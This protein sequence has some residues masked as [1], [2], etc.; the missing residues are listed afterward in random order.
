MM[1]AAK[2]GH[3]TVTP[4]YKPALEEKLAFALFHHPELTPFWQ[5]TL[6]IATREHLERLLPR[7]WILTRR[8]VPPTAIIPG[9][10]W[11]A[12]PYPIFAV[13]HNPAKKSA[14]SCSS[15]RDSRNWLGVAEGCRSAMICRR[16]SGLRRWSRRS[17]PF[18][19]PPIFC[20]SFTKGV[21]SSPPIS[22]SEPIGWCR[23]LGRAR[24]SSLLFCRRRQ[25]RTRRNPRHPLSS[26]QKSYSRHGRRHHGA[27]RDGA[28]CS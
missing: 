10:R 6:T 21:S 9:L 1:Y 27:L 7:T 22:T 8:P 17:K 14:N 18:R 26:R 16:S 4:P 2:K 13:W 5:Q 23:C 20:R 19:P 11:A 15:R 12:G 28:D 3:V 24:L 25:G